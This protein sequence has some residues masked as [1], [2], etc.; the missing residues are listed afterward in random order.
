MKPLFLANHPAL[1][2]LNTKLAPDGRRVELLGTGVE[3]VEWL[4][5]ANLLDKKRAFDL[6]RRTSAR[7]LDSAAEE[8]R[9]VR[10]WIRGWLTRWRSNPQGD[11]RKEIAALNGLL[12]RASYSRTV[13]RDERG[14]SVVD[15]PQLQDADGL[16]VL[17]ASQLA[18]LLTVQQPALIKD[19]ANP[20]CTLWFL[21]QTKSH[22][23][24]FCSP[25]ACGNRVRVAA[26]RQRQR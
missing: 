10:E 26:F 19:C 4:V 18:A 15:Q 12:S 11:Y 22:R 13:L 2:F 1:D 24:M 17:I 21:D 9:R 5:A 6:A 3:Y 23:R 14:L 25:S 7:A 8:A 16:L 20:A